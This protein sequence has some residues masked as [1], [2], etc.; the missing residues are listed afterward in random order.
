MD[1]EGSIKEQKLSQMRD[2]PHSKSSNALVNEQKR[3]MADLIVYDSMPPTGEIKPQASADKARQNSTSSGK[4]TNI[5][6][7]ILRGNGFKK[8]GRPPSPII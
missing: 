4:L 1:S 8:D 5:A 3:G 7:S 6:A 2:R